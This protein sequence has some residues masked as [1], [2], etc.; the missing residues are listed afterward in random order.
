[1]DEQF[2]KDLINHI[3]E[4]FDNFE[5]PTADEG[6]LELRKKFPE[7]RSRRPV[8][9]IW[10]GA[11]A[12]LVLLCMSIGFLIYDGRVKPTTVARTKTKFPSVENLVKNK[13]ASNGATNTGSKEETK[14]S[15]TTIAQ[16]NSFAQSPATAKRHNESNYPADIKRQN[17]AKTGNFAAAGHQ[18]AA[19]SSPGKT[20]LS[21]SIAL[22]T[23]V[24][25]QKEIQDGTGNQIP[26]LKD[27]SAIVIAS[28]K[29]SAI[30][31]K[32]ADSAAINTMDAKQ[33]LAAN[34]NKTGNT[35]SA[36]N[37]SIINPANTTLAAVKQA[38][39]RKIDAADP[40]R[41]RLAISA[42]T[43]VNYAKGS[44]SQ[45][46]V[47][48]GF[49]SDIPLTR[50]LSLVTGINVAQNS[51]NF[52]GTPPPAIQQNQLV[53]AT[54]PKTAS[55]ASASF[56]PVSTPKFQNYNAS[57]IGLDIPV[58]LK[59]Q[60]NPKKSD[61]YV[62]AG[63]SSGIFIDENYVY[64]YNYPS[65]FSPAVQQT[66]GT[67]AHNRFNNF[68][69]AKVVNV[70]FGVGRQI[71]RNRVIIEPFLKYP[72]AGVGSQQLHFGTGGVNLKLNLL[73]GKK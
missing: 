50:K 34:S 63:L 33:L 40:R 72:L 67:T 20:A 32:I 44:S 56:A 53:A 47:G 36:N 68:Y 48:L 54:A 66:L 37:K 61:T 65:L 2:D 1:M 64:K 31:G 7:K 3:R 4:A 27:N 17:L 8:A 22:N 43:Y 55:F 6:W 30:P 25:R 19:Q 41:I 16:G 26:P 12:A 10:R 21:N 57:L 45:M 59:Y 39:V 35:D 15:N 70:A 14:L 58:N 51:L 23:S 38:K 71:G 62:S 49:S 29:N 18:Y 13:P 73:S 46:N 5:D 9:W 11:A 42:G 28:A 69:V 52:A 60:F 24:A